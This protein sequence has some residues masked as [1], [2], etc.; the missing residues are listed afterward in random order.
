MIENLNF[1]FS[2]VTYYT[3]KKDKNS[4]QKNVV[5]W[6]IFN[7]EY[8]PLKVCIQMHVRIYTNIKY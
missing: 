2:T 7:N 6:K 3:H 1:T 4:E 5:N 8:R